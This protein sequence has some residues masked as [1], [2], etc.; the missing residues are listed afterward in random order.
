MLTHLNH[1]KLSKQLLNVGLIAL[2]F[3]FLFSCSETKKTYQT[4]P[5]LIN[6]TWKITNTS[7]FFI[8]GIELKP[9]GGTFYNTGDTILRYAFEIKMDSLLLTDVNGVTIPNQITKL[10]KDSLIFKTLLWD[11]TQQSF[12][13]VKSLWD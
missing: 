1:E 13:R 2:I 11:T 5:P 9:T 10:T 8:T 7:N 3:L 12:V 6:G 4:F